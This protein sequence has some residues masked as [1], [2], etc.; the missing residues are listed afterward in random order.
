M[1]FRIF[2]TSHEPACYFNILNVLT[3]STSYLSETHSSK[4][5]LLEHFSISFYFYIVFEKENLT[6]VF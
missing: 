5:N 4:S 6:C 3:L 2:Y 1:F